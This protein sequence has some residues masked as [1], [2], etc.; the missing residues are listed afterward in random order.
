[1]SLKSFNKILWVK[2]LFMHMSKK[3]LKDSIKL[4]NKLPFL[5]SKDE[6]SNLQDLA[7]ILAKRDYN[8]EDNP[9]VKR[10]KERFKKI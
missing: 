9:A 4:N 1:M 5:D 10:L 2:K 8:P 7:R 3:S 6:A